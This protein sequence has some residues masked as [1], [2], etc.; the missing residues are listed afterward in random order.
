VRGDVRTTLVGALAGALLLSI[1]ASTRP[2][3][4][5][6]QQPADR[7]AEND[8]AVP[9]DQQIEACTAA[10][11]SGRWRGAGLAWAY[12]NRS[13]AYIRRGEFDRG[14]ADADEAIRLD[15]HDAAAFN[16]RGNGYRMK[17]EY[18]R[19]IAD[20]TQT[21][22]L[23]PTYVFAFKNR[24]S[25]Y[26]HQGDLDR[27]IADY[28][29]AVRLDPTF[30]NAFA[31]RAS[32]YREKGDFDRAIADFST[33]I[34][35]SPQDSKAFYSRGVAYRLQGD[36][37]HALTDYDQTIALNP[38]NFFAFHN[39]AGIY[40]VKGDLDRAIADYDAAI[41]LYPN[42]ATFYYN[43]ATTNV[44]AGSLPKALTDFERAAEL[45]P[46]SEYTA[47][48]I[49]ILARRNNSPSELAAKAVQFDMSRWPAPIVRLYLGQATLD[50]VLAAAADGEPK[51]KTE[52]LCAAYF[53]G[54]EL[55]LSQ[56]AKDEAARLFR[57][58]VDNCAKT[59]LPRV[60]A[61]AELKALSAMP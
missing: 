26:Q 36:I 44:Y 53:F 1:A 18:D 19:A 51:I 8:Q 61:I 54:G 5:Q 56:G 37:D 33:L 47:L 48:W 59:S 3:I 25:V 28:S 42:E 20:Y 2:G 32:A 4:A 12:N 46:R 31:D 23:D 22:R 55:A 6:S 35:L 16:N 39:R 27:A 49:D 14:I 21:I 43:R 57:L 58:A 30:P 34:R 10:I 38:A 9:L 41:R 17:E 50:E 15:P 45:K 52:Q 11:E 7:C 24:G 40:H 29:E 13:F 60:D